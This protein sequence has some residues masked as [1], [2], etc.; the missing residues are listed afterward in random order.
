MATSTV[1]TDRRQLTQ[2]VKAIAREVG[3]DLVGI[4]LMGPAT[5]GEAFLAWLAA[6][7]H[8]PMTQLEAGVDVRTDPRVRH[9]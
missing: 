2:Q 6:G 8:Q 9:P 3:F 7:K 4:A 5:Y 1:L